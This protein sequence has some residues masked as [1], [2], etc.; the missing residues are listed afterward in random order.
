MKKLSIIAVLATLATTAMAVP[1]NL[2]PPVTIGG[3]ESSSTDVRITANVVQG[4]A[5]N[6]ASPID[7]GNLPKNIYE[8]GSNISQNIPGKI[9]VKGAP[10]ANIN[11]KLDTDKAVLVWSGFNGSPDDNGTRALIDEVSVYGLTKVD[12][13]VVLGSNGEYTRALTASFP[14]GKTA[15]K[16]LGTNQKLGSYVGSVKV[17]ATVKK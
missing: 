13:V 12:E 11:L 3:A 1:P 2:Q 7:F 4:V 5:V 6:E 9:V 10:Q 8:D 14:A 17:I 15:G 16:N